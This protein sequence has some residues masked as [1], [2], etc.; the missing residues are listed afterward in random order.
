M[1]HD[2]AD[3]AVRPEATEIEIGTPVAFGSTSPGDVLRLAAYGTP[4]GEG[5]VLER[6]ILADASYRGTAARP[7]EVDGYR[8]PTDDQPW[9]ETEVIVDG[10]RWTIARGDP[11]ALVERLVRPDRAT[12]VRAI[13]E[14]ARLTLGAYRPLGVAYRQG[15]GDWVMAGYV[16]VRGWTRPGRRSGGRPFDY[17][18]VWDLSLRLA[19]W[20]WVAAIIVLT[21]SGYLLAQPSWIPAGY[22][23]PPTEFFVGYVRLVHYVAAVVLCLVLLVRAYGLSVSTIPYDR[24]KALIPFRS[25]RAVVN[26]V[27]T[28]RG[29][30]FIKPHETPVYFGHN[31]LQQLT[32]TSVYVILLLQIATGFALWSLFNPDGLFLEWFGW[33]N[34]L[35]GTAQVRLLHYMIMWGLLVFIPAHVYLSVRADSVERMGAISSMVSGGRWVRRGAVFEDWP[36]PDGGNSPAG[37]ELR[38]EDDGRAGR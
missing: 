4:P 25:R 36:N 31:P 32:Y 21:V 12:H 28:L 19:H 26:G 27:K 1:S 22:T 33:I 37:T 15:D 6:A 16:P 8:P 38:A 2:I 10:A 29:Y 5:N 7:T 18:S 14:S 13:G 20:T 34:E 11:R 9:S 30:L 3:S 23:D 24:W 35:L 17:H